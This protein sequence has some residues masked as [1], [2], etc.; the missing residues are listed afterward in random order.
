MIKRKI[1]RI[2]LPVLV[3]ISYIIFGFIASVMTGETDLILWISEH[4]LLLALISSWI[5]I[6]FIRK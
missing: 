2:S 5:I 6:R 1:R 4:K 3:L